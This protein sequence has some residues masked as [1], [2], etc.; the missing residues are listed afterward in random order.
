MGRRSV[1]ESMRPLAADPSRSAL[2]KT[3]LRGP[4]VTKVHLKEAMVRL[5]QYQFTRS[6]SLDSGCGQPGSEPACQLQRSL[7]SF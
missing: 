1:T 3:G 4:Q 5:Q 6:P 2:P 7:T